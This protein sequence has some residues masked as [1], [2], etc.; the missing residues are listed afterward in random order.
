MY[1]QFFRELEVVLK[2]Q[3]GVRQ[4]LVLRISN[5]YLR[6]MKLIIFIECD[7]Y[8]CMQGMEMQFTKT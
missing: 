5:L 1:I 4:F 8:F 7:V 6:L 2:C 3:R